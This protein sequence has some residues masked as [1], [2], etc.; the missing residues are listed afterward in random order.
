MGWLR[1]KKTWRAASMLDYVRELNTCL[2]G[3]RYN[4]PPNDARNEPQR[5]IEM[6]TSTRKRTALKGTTAPRASSEKR[7]GPQDGQLK[8][9]T[10]YCTQCREVLKELRTQRANERLDDVFIS[11]VGP[12]VLGVLNPLVL[13]F[14]GLVG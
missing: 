13:S 14:F 11:K 6:C 12:P 1:E 7:L 4:I 5:T 10:K 2:F 8:S 3:T 9:S